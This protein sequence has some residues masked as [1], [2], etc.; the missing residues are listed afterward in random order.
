MQSIIH[1]SS[2]AQITAIHKRQNNRVKN[3][4]HRVTQHTALKK[5][6]QIL[7]DDVCNPRSQNHRMVEFGMAFWTYLEIAKTKL[8]EVFGVPRN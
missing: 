8:V 1:L 5:H 3:M 2:N 4:C 6:P 7:F